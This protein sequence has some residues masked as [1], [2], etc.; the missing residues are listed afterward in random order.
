METVLALMATL[1][2]IG[3]IVVAQTIRAILKFHSEYY[4]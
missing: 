3:V 4:D 1:F 2:V